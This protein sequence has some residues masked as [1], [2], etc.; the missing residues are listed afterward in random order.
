MGVFFLRRLLFGLVAMFVAMSL[1]FYYFASKFFPLRET[2]TWHAYWV[3][4][5]G[6]PNGRSL[7]H[8]LIYP[9]LLPVVGAAFG[10]TMLLL[11]L[12]LVIVVAIAIPVGCISAARR[13]SALDAGLRIGTYVAWAVPGFVV[14][15]V[16]Q[17]GFGRVA[18][19]WGVGWFPPAGWAGNCPGGVGVDLHNFQCPAA[20][21]GLTHVGQVLYH[22]ALPA[23][24]LALGFIAVNA[25]YLRNALVDTLD[26]PYITVARGKGLTEQNVLLRHAL[27][28]AF[29]T[30]VPAL[31]SGFGLIFGAALAIDF[32]FRLGG[33]GTLFLTLLPYQTDGIIQVDTYALMLLM[34]IAAAFMV[35]VSTFSEAVVALLDPRMRFD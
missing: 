33:V 13:G 23:L 25:R 18:G 20:G 19:G 26:A 29:V 15:I 22:L 30:F 28:N 3:W 32:I 27:R 21:H 14:A 35:A 16:L 6:I 1:T 2:S 10:R 5:R 12:T 24:A 7:T 11:A 17:D 34:L 9:H 8:G 31:V 4:L